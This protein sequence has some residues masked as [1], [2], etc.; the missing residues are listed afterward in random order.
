MK[1][2]Y[3][4]K[5]GEECGLVL[6]HIYI[7]GKYL[8]SSE[9]Q[10]LGNYF[11]YI[12]TGGLPR[13]EHIPEP[14]LLKTGKPTI[15]YSRMQKQKENFERM[16]YEYGFEIEK[17]GHS[18]TNPKYS[19][20]ADIIAIDKNVKGKDKNKKRIIIDLK[21]SGMLNDKWSPYGWASE[22]IE[23]KWDLLI[24]AIHYKMLAKYEWGIDDIPFYFFVFSNKN[25]YECKVFEIIVDETTRFQHT[26]NLRNIKTYL[27]EQ[28]AMGLKAKPDYNRCNKCQLAETCI[29][30]VNV[31]IPQ[32]VYI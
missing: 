19:G 4:Y 9:V 2:L 1:S 7:K 10:E 5:N 29:Q 12:C 16:M 17:V 31:P 26:N 24:Q 8:P 22:S 30:K 6:E 32:K 13:D 3:K 20:I 25:D 15:Q 27:D 23:E 21:S 11:E 14:K 28:L 18:F